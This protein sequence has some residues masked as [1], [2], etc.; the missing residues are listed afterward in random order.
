MD[1]SFVLTDREEEYLG[2]CDGKSM[3]VVFSVLE[4]SQ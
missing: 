4:V 2:T 3:E 1:H